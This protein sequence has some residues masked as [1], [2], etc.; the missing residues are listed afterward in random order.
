MKMFVDWLFG[1]DSQE[2]C[3]GFTGRTFRNRTKWVWDYWLLPPIIE[4]TYD[5]VFLDGIYL[6][7][8]CVVLIAMTKE[9]V[10][11]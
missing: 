3:A 9:H 8:S 10:L 2:E 5:V 11:G 7:R 1:K 4:E 6:T